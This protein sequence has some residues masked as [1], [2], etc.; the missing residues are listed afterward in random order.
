MHA[1]GR[2]QLEVVTDEGA[3]VTAQ[4]DWL[5]ALSAVG[6]SDF[7]ISGKSPQSKVE[8]ETQGGDKDRVYLV[9]GMINASGELVLP[10]ARFRRS[11]A[12]GAAR[13]LADLAEKGPPGKQEKKGALGLTFKQFEGLHEALS[14]SV[15]FSTRGVKR[16]EV[17]RK[18]A[19]KLPVPV[20]IDPGTLKAADEDK[21]SEELSDLS[22]G[23]AL[24]CVLRPAGLCLVPR[25]GR[26][27]PELA[28]V[29]AEKGLN[30]WP[31]GWKPD[32]PPPKVLPPLY[33]SFN[34]DI[35]GALLT[36]VLDALTKRLKAPIL[37]DHNALARH[38]IEPEKIHI[39]VP[40]G[41]TMHSTL[42]RR[43]LSQAQLKMELRVDE[44][45]N[46]LIWVTTVKP[47]ESP[48]RD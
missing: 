36:T 20:K 29:A 32:Q 8:I 2:V 6:V 17:A 28:V 22:C 16:S 15:G 18:I 34:A 24:A 31:I 12:A 45:G 41:R 9:T 42:L 26:S 44:A 46:P 48:G 14:L 13:W 11:Q 47:N 3:G 23:T 39:S 40:A 37:L 21:V 5:Q 27:G 30:I 10:G 4:Q 25:G 38:G 43:V 7:R 33:E 35:Q 1:Q 19:A